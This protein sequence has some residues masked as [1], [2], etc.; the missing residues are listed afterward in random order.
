MHREQES[1][2]RGVARHRSVDSHRR[3]P[4]FAP[5]VR[6][7]PDRRAEPVDA[8]PSR[9]VAQAAAV[10]GAVRERDHSQRE[11]DRRAAARAAGGESGIVGV[12]GCAIDGIEG[13]GAEAEFGGVGLADDDRAR[14]AKPLD[15][16]RILS[17]HE[18]LEQRR[19][20]RHGHA[21]HRREILDRER[22]PEQGAAG[23]P[24]ILGSRLG[25]TVLAGAPRDDRVEGRVQRVDPVE[26]RFHELDAGEFAGLQPPHEF[27]R[28]ETEDLRRDRGR[29]FRRHLSHGIKSR[30]WRVCRTFNSPFSPRRSKFLLRG[31]FHPPARY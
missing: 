1:K 31:S 21:L 25:Q 15:E 3:Q 12:A 19:A 20:H 28:V 11:R 8:V 6:N 10:I 16:D 30:F 23:G 4:D 9:G 29:H 27:D 5:I 2:V 22:Q 14:R 24:G 7:A 13:L 17:W 26:R 18:A